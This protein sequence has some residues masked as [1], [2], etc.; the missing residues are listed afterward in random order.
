MKK[1]KKIELVFYCEIDGI[2]T[3][4][5]SEIMALYARMVKEG[6]AD[7]VF[8]DGTINSADEWLQAMKSEG[9]NLYVIYVEDEIAGVVWLNRLELKKA[10]LHFC[11]FTLESERDSVE[12]GKEVVRYFM[13]MG[14]EDDYLFDLLYGIVP[15]SNK[16]AIEYVKQVGAVHIGTMPHGL[17]NK[18]TG[19]TEAAA[20]LC[21]T[22]R[23]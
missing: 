14:V 2:R 5:D 3:F 1:K 15:E 23:H 8:V 13:S 10:R 17:W 6:T 21:Y 18:I 9:N 11:L 7:T 22:R 20:I 16:K 4:R 19:K 12:I